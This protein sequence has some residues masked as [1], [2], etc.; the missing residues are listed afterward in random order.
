V[1]DFARC[2]AEG[3]ISPL[4]FEVLL[5]KFIAQYNALWRFVLSNNKNKYKAWH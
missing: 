4:Y 1:P 3:F 5:G 2:M